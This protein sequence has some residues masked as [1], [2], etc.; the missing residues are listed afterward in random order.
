MN[1]FLTD[2]EL[3]KGTIVNVGRIAKFGS[4]GGAGGALSPAGNGQFKVWDDESQESAAAVAAGN[5]PESLSIFLYDNADKA[6]EKKDDRGFSDDVAAGGLIGKVILF[7]GFIGFLLVI[8]R[9]AFLSLFS[10]DTNKIKRKVSSKV[11]EG[12]L[13][14]ALKFCKK[15]SNSASAVI[16]ATLR[17][18]DKDRDHVEDII[19]ESILHESSRIDRFGAA[20][21]VIAAVSP[22][23]GLLGTVTGMIGTFDIIT[24]FGTGDPKLLSSGISEALVTTKFGLVVA[25]PLL[26]LGNVLSS[27]G[28]RIKRRSGAGCT[29]YDQYLQSIKSC[30]FSP[31]SIPWPP[32]LK[33]VVS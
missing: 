25:I 23:L 32:I 16:A 29:A 6:I 9:L 8:A 30:R 1:S 7:I 18:L 3:A 14:G 10:S 20:I 31:A 4:A 5:T 21:L 12:D 2:G 11:K 17:N 26:L 27:W 19:S 33:W 24:E 28:T 13:K 15:N 22:L